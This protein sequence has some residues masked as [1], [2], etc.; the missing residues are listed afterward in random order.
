MTSPKIDYY[1]GID[2]QARTMRMVEVKGIPHAMLMDPKGIVR[3]EG[4]PEYLTEDGLARLIA[5]YAD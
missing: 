4:M 2:T 3:F 1:V 5:K